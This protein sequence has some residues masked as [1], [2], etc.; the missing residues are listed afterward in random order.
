MLYMVI[1]HLKRLHVGRR[2]I[3]ACVLLCVCLTFL[4]FDEEVNEIASYHRNLRCHTLAEVKDV[5][6]MAESLSDPCIVSYPEMVEDFVLSPDS[7]EAK[8]E[9]TFEIIPEEDDD[10][11]FSYLQADDG[12]IIITPPDTS[13]EQGLNDV[14]FDLLDS[15][16]PQI[17]DPVK[18]V[19]EATP[20]DEDAVGYIVV[21]T[22]C[23][24]LEDSEP[25]GVSPTVESFENDPVVVTDL[26]EASAVLKA[27]VCDIT[28]QAETARQLGQTSKLRQLETLRVLSAAEM[29]YTM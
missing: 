9:P 2:T 7:E 3:K 13:E 11:V 4:F 18:A 28:E 27:E 6:K 14:E 12:N 24:T 19:A 8:E 22:E 15:F 10:S 20:D 25:D 21:A 26:Y 16:Q 1:H 17:Y 23:P 5:R 29:N